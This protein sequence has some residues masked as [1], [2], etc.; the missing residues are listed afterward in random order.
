VILGHLTN[1]RTLSSYYLPSSSRTVIPDL[2][3]GQLVRLG[4]M[5]EKE[6]KEK[7]G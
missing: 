2:R 3:F 6:K 1:A 4:D 5:Q 7:K